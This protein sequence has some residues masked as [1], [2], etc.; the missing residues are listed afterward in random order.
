M[1]VSCTSTAFL[2]FPLPLL[3]TPKI[4]WDLFTSNHW[5][6]LLSVTCSLH[7]PAQSKWH[8]RFLHQDTSSLLPKTKM[9]QSL[10]CPPSSWLSAGKSLIAMLRLSV[11]ILSTRTR[12]Y[13]SWL[14]RILGIHPSL[15]ADWTMRLLWMRLWPRPILLLMLSRIRYSLLQRLRKHSPT[16]HCPLQ[17]NHPH[18]PGKG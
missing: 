2:T 12:T 8:P 4:D 7:H 1:S 10:H 15:M 11:Q 5:M 16:E 9:N 14:L 17:L 13:I 3:S 6:N 18:V